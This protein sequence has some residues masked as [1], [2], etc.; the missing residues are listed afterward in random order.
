MARFKKIGGVVLVIWSA[1]RWIPDLLGSAQATAKYGKWV[2]EHL[3]HLHLVYLPS[4]LPNVVVLV[5]G[6]GLIFSE[7][8]QRKIHQWWNSRQETETPQQQKP[9]NPIQWLKDVKTYNAR[10]LKP[11][12]DGPNVVVEYGYSEERR[13]PDQPLPL[14]SAPLTLVNISNKDAAHNVRVLP[15]T[16]GELTAAFVPDV[17]PFIEPAGGRKEVTALIGGI[18]PDLK[19]DF[20]ILFERNYRG[21]PTSELEKPH[22]HTLL[23][24]YDDTANAKRF[25]TVVTLRYTRYKNQITVGE[26]KRRI[27]Q[28]I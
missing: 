22:P 17:I 15:I 18:F 16:V 28:L 21:G 12:S 14:G 19:H 9:G 24:E 1:I 23:I 25:E 20:P 3:A 10:E 11:T 6:I 27:K 5:I 2:Y 4:G 7:T 8:I 13:S 26:T